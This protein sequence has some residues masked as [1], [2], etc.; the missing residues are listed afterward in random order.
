MNPDFVEML[1]ELSASGADFLV[2]GAHALAAHGHPR[3]TGDLDVWVRADPENAPR[4]LE[5]LRRFG[6]PLFDLSVEDLSRPGTVF[7]IGTAPARIDILTGVSGLT[8]EQAWPRRTTVKLGELSV[9]VIGREDL[10][11]NKR[12]TGRPQVLV[13]AAV[14]E[15]HRE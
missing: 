12:A 2:V 15:Q 6:A 13:D 7:Q 3:A 1:S 8:F 4:V 9:G 11:R 14:L 5:A 10:I